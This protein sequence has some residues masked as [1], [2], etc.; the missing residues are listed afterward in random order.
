M[1]IAVKAHRIAYMALPKAGCSTVKAALAQVDPEVALPETGTPD[2]MR[3]H[4][5]YPTRRFRPHRWEAYDGWWR[6]CVVRDPLTRLLSLYT[7]RVVEMRELH[8]CRKILRGRVA[9]PTDPDPD[10]FFQN[11]RA[12]IRAASTVK[13]HALPAWLFL[14]HD[15]GRYDRIYR[16]DELARL[17][18]DLA[19]RTRC[20][21]R[22]ARENA[23]AT[24]LTL[25]DLAP[26]TRT[27]LRDHL[28]EEYAY[29]A[30]F[31]E[32]P[33]GQRQHLAC[34]GPLRRVS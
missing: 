5:L 3:W 2:V 6:F 12:Y 13:H 28:A 16:T 26:R 33:F 1:V 7:N 24:R 19:E 14:G 10:F 21:V 32:N 34:T 25:E 11:L 27:A 8:N 17:G 20:P 29:L 4:R 18:A 31:Y 15:L 9:L 22:I 23:S 30:E